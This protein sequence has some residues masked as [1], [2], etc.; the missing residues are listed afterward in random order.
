MAPQP[1]S[2]RCGACREEGHNRR[3]CPRLLMDGPPTIEQS[4][5]LDQDVQ[6]LKDHADDSSRPSVNT[7]TTGNTSTTTSGSAP[8]VNIPPPCPV[9][10]NFAGLDVGADHYPVHGW[11]L[12]LT[13]QRGQDIP[14]DWYRQTVR[15]ARAYAVKAVIAIERGGA[16]GHRHVQGLVVIKWGT[17]AD[18]IKK[19]TDH[20]KR[21]IPIGRFRVG[22]L[23]S[24][25][26]KP[27][28]EHQ[29]I[30]EMIGYC[31]KDEGLS[32]FQVDVKGFTTE[33]ATVHRLRPK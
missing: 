32:H 25:M 4:I 24:L 10:P 2:Q 13:K 27:L 28:E 29:G 15:W 3:N 30:P 20:L 26:L 14:D 31:L 12:T 33:D 19:L 9:V 18:D 1:G 17:S 21:Y 23:G 6:R 5:N 16:R 22:S 11:S 7:T 8:I